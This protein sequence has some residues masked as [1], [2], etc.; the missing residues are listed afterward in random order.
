MIKLK[1]KFL[2]KII[3]Y[4]KEKLFHLLEI[5]ENGVKY[6]EKLYEKIEKKKLENINEILKKLEKI[7]EQIKEYSMLTEF[8]SI[9][10]QDVIH[11]VLEDYEDYLNEIEK[12]DEQLKIA[13]KNLFLYKGIKNAI[14]NF[15]NLCAL[16]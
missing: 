4:I 12:K 6:S 13:K 3:N 9:M 5:V 8:I 14:K 2:K 15:I 11:T 16:L 1:T 10:I 7:D